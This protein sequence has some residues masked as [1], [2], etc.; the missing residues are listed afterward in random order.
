MVLEGFFFF[1]FGS[2]LNVYESTKGGDPLLCIGEN[3]RLTFV[4]GT[5]SYLIDSFRQAF[6]YGM[7]L[8]SSARGN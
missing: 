4:L 6:K 1:F 5:C 7:F 3:S 2:L 8:K